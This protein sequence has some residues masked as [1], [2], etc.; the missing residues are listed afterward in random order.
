MCLRATIHAVMAIEI[1]LNGETREVPAALNIAELLDHFEIPRDR[2]A[3]ERNRSI[4]SKTEWEKVSV[5]AGDQLEVVHFVGG[6][7]TTDNDPFVIADRTF[8]SRLIVG[9]GKYPSHDVMADAHQ[10]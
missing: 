5:A 7:D 4:V 10:R 3:V 1:Q 2:V 9:T 6:G 8:Q